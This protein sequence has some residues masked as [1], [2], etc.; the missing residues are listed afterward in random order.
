[1]ESVVSRRWSVRAT[2]IQ[3]PEFRSQKE[4]SLF[5]ILA[6]DSWLPRLGGCGVPALASLCVF[7]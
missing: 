6:P 7:A 4:L 2:R 5:W 1:M 3:E